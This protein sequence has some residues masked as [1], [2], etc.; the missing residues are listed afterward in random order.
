MDTKNVILELRTKKGLSQ[1]ELAGKVMVTRQAVS[2]WENGETVPNTETLKLL[3]KEFNVTINTLLGAPK[4]LI[5]QC[6]GMPLEDEMVG[7]DSDGSLN[8]DYCKWCYADGTY[9]YSDMDDLIDEYEKRGGSFSPAIGVNSDVEYNVEDIEAAEEEKRKAREEAMQQRIQEDLENYQYTISALEETTNAMCNYV[10]Q[11][12]NIDRDDESILS[13]NAIFLTGKGGIGKTRTLKKVLKDKNMHKNSDYIWVSSESITSDKLYKLMYDYNGKLIVFDDTADLF[14]GKYNLSLWKQVFQ[15]EPEDRELGF[16]GRDSKLAVYDDREVKDR[17]RRYFMEIGR[18]SL[19]D[20]T[21]FFQKEMKKYGLKWSN[22]NAKQMVASASSGLEED[23]VIE[24]QD[25]IEKLWKEEENNTKPL[26]PTHFVFTGV[27][28][29]ISNL[30][31]QDMVDQ[32]GAKQWGAM[33]SRLKTYDVS[34]LSETLWA[35]MKEVI[36][37]EYNDKNLPDDNCAIPRDMTEEFIE[38]VE[39]LIGDPE[40]QGLSWRTIKAFGKTLRGAPGLRVWKR[41]LK[42]ELRTI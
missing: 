33:K 29:F 8:E 7:H 13:K 4:Q 15:T 2:R 39:S 5:C 34:P 19:S 9:T 40:Y 23:E 12:G 20:K 42:D 30:E 35:Q 21:E 32:L 1:D 27:I 14:E 31:M 3:S 18:K 25:K 11:H 28:I 24:L 6:C 41:E 10:K 37:A 26:I 22:R 17:Q 16:P 36:L 38:E